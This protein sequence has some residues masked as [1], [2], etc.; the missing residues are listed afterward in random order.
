MQR[1][2]QF[3]D[4]EITLAES[5]TVST[6]SLQDYDQIWRQTRSRLPW[7][8]LFVSPFWLE[9][10]VNHLGAA[11]DPLVLAIAHEKAVVGI[12]PYVSKVKTLFSLE[13][14]MCATIKMLSWRPDTKPVP[15][16][17]R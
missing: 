5:Y 13:F 10:V 1:D 14:Q 11:G 16:N 2:D 8:C 17:R 6:A 9:T 4:R 7:E 3:P 15:W 12:L